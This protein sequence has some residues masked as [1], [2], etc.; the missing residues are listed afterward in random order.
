M[1]G[2][3]IE[4][5]KLIALEET[6]AKQQEETLAKLEKLRA[7]ATQKQADLKAKQEKLKALQKANKKLEEELHATIQDIPS[8]N[9]GEAQAIVLTKINTDP[10][11]TEN[12]LSKQFDQM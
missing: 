11:P 3:D 7:S 4:I 5:D 6:K 2:N 9:H 8:E 12:I 1:K 10:S